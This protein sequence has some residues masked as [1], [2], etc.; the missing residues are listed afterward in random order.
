MSLG[1]P[2]QTGL[3]PV[4]NSMAE[5]VVF[6]P[7]Q[8]VGVRRNTLDGVADD[9]PVDPNNPDLTLLHRAEHQ[10]DEVN[11][12]VPKDPA[13]ALAFFKPNLPPGFVA[14]YDPRNNQYALNYGYRL[15]VGAHE[16]E[17][18][19]AKKSAALMSQ[20]AADQ[21]AEAKVL[22]ALRPAM[23]QTLNGIDDLTSLGGKLGVSLTDH[24]Y[25]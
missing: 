12:A 21:A 10:G 9:G 23:S 16:A 14:V 6:R 3:S 20:R 17:Q 7:G 24:T 15:N 2:D 13:Q 5:P 8:L 4:Y 25:D 22:P 11:V 1:R 18:I 19:R